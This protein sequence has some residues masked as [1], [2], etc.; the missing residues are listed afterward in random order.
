[1]SSSESKYHPPTKEI[2]SKEQLEQFQA[3]ET[4][5]AIIAYIQ[6]LNESVVGVR[7]TDPCDE[8]EAVKAII[9]VLDSVAH[10]ATETPPVDNAGSR[11]GNP[12]FRDFYDKVK[13]SSK[14]LHSRIAGIPEDSVQEISLYFEESWGNRTRIDYGSGMELNFLCWLYC[15]ERLGVLR[16]EDDRAVVYIGVM[17]V[18]QSTYWLEPAGSHGV[19]GLDDYHFL[20][21]LFG[22][23]Q[24]RGHRHL[25]PKSIHDNEILEEFSKDYMYL[26]CIQF[27]NSIKTASLRWHSPM[28]D[29]ISAVKTWDKVNA[30][31]I[32]M[33]LAE[34]MGKLPVIQH[35]L[36]GTIL[37]FTGDRTQSTVDKNDPHYGH[38]HAH[39][40]D[41]GGAGQATVGWG[42]CCGIPVPSAF[43][44]AAAAGK[45]LQGPGIRPVPFD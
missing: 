16:P 11:F 10:L 23:A 29:D 35:F 4:H 9:G 17:R 2:L 15:L 31:M 33:Y 5:A 20:P 45:P 36:F 19:W 8:S 3:S 21:F 28:L 41:L 37:P 44:A 18:L 24:L 43:G 39:N 6:R 7:L 25:R 14:E 26:A 27:I 22:S 1:M 40:G 34:V 30:G 32:K 12:A 13:A 42:D 38:A